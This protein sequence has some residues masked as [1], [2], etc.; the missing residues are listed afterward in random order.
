MLKLKVNRI[1]LGGMPLS[2][3]NRPSEA[4]ALQVIQTAL[5]L[6]VDFID[7]AN[8]Y[9]T[10]NEDIGHNERLIA[11]ALKNWHGSKPIYI[12]TKGGLERPNGAWTQNAQPDALRIACEKSL[13]AL[14][15]E[16]IF[17]YQLHAVDPKVP[18]EDSLGELTRLHQEGKIEHIGLSNVDA[19]EIERALAVTQ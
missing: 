10:S 3:Q 7:T 9:C 2:I 16:R 15:T 8:V 13:K 6:G 14:E 18:L 17:L 11:K 1:G 5:E 12:G 19:L 4:D